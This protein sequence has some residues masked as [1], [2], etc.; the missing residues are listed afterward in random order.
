M[1]QIKD[2]NELRTY[3]WAIKQV[4]MNLGMKLI[5]AAE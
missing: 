1:E 5:E 3:L 2:L 4:N